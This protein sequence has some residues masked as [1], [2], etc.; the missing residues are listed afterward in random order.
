MLFIS[1]NVM[2]SF[3][4]KDLSKFNSKVGEFENNV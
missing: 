3:K 2:M 4:V 1:Y